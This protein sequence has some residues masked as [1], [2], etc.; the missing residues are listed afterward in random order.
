MKNLLAAFV[1]LL[2]TTTPGRAQQDNAA[3][4]AVVRMPSHGA[5]AT[6]IY[7]E[8]HR[9]YVLSCAH[10]FEG[11]DKV[12]PI[13]LDLPATSTTAAKNVGITLVAVD[14]QA[15]LSLLE[16]HDGPVEFVCSVAPRNFRVGSSLL[17]VGYDE[18]RLPALR[19]PAHVVLQNG[20]TTFTREAPWHGRSGGALID[21]KYVVGVVSGYETTQPR[22]GIYVSHTAIVDFLD[23]YVAKCNGTA[24]PTPQVREGLRQEILPYCL[25]GGH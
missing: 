13:K 9:T 3:I 20:G 7:T 4:S 23:G 22:R 8:P 1:L 6:V 12:K 5:S 2:V 19:L 18:M 10:A 11:N 16:M 17:S 21:G 25:P 14:Y 15:D 24:R